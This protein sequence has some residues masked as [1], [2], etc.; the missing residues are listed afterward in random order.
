MSTGTSRKMPRTAPLSYI[1]VAAICVALAVVSW[2]FAFS[3]QP[4][5][6]PV[7]CSMPSAG[8]PVS[9]TSLVGVNFSSPSEV[10]VRVFNANGETGQATTVADQLRTL[11]FTP[12]SET[13]FGNDPQ[14]PEQNLECFGQLRFG[15]GNDSQVVALHSLLPCFELIQD[16]RQD[17]SVD[18]SLGKGFEALP[19]GGQISDAMSALNRG[20][21][22][23]SATLENLAPNTCG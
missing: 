14:V 5:S 3:Q 10:P 8:T 15:A 23:D 11:G 18:V 13:P 17:P 16:G 20:E 6:Y 1:A 9:S 12:D 21:Q 19:T 2:V 7:A 22:V 4:K